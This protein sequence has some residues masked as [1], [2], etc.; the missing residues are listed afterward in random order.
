MI[1]MNDIKSQM[2]KSEYKKL[3][4]GLQPRHQVNHTFETKKKKK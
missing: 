3:T 2:M 1:L 4:P